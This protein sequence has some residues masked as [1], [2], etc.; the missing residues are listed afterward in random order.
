MMNNIVY[1]NDKFVG[2]EEAHISPNDRGFL[3]SDGIYEVIRS[4]DGH[5]FQVEAHLKRL[6]YGMT[7]LR[8]PEIKIENLKEIAYQLLEYN[9][10]NN[11][12]ALIYVQITRGTAPRTHKFPPQGTSPTIYMSA[13]RFIHPPNEREQGVKVILV[14][15]IRW[16]RCDIK[17]IALLPNVLARQQAT[18]NGAAEAIFIRDGVAMEGTHCNFCAIFNEELVTPPVTNYI[19]SGITRKVV[20]K[21]CEEIGIPVREAPIFEHH[22][23]DAD[24]LMIVGTTVEITPVVKVN[25]WQVG[26]GKPGQIIR[27][28]QANFRNKIHSL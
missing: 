22:L 19:L 12:E 4:Y 1:L 5:L 23:K 28:I 17:T 24:E 16:A 6:Q 21:I 9:K 3:F 13:T 18:E 7:E 2:F 11:G 25:K 27:R 10:L 15:D 14:P 26:N 20:L 8:L